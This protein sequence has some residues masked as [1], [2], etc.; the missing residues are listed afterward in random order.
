MVSGGTLVTTVIVRVTARLLDD[1]ERL[2]LLHDVAF[3]GADL[4]HSARD[5]RGHRDL[6]LHRLEDHQRV[7]LLHML[8]NLHDDLP[9]IADELRLHLSHALSLQVCRHD[10]RLTPAARRACAT[11][12]AAAL[13][14][15]PRARR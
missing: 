1:R 14:P 5:R 9:E 2:T 15:R 10:A 3:L 12:A 4:F 11:A 13:S 6:H 8:T 7:V